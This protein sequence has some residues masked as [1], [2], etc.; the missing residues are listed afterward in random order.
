M[1]LGQGNARRIELLR[2]V[3]AV[4]PEGVEDAVQVRGETRVIADPQAAGGIKGN[5]DPGVRSRLGRLL[6]GCP[7]RTL[8]A[9]GQQVLQ[10]A[11]PGE[12]RVGRL[13]GIAQRA[14][15]VDRHAGGQVGRRAGWRG[16]DGAVGGEGHAAISRH[17]DEVFVT[18]VGRIVPP[19]VPRHRHDPAMI[20]RHGRYHPVVFDVTRRAVVIDADRTGPGPAFVG[21]AHEPDVRFASPHVVP[22]HVDVVAM[23][24][25][26]AR[27]RHHDRED[28]AAEP[29]RSIRPHVGTQL[30]R[31]FRGAEGPATVGRA[32]HEERP[33]VV[34]FRG[35]GEVILVIGHQKGAVGQDHRLGR[36]QL[37]AQPGVDHLP[38]GE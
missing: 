8:L 20:H 26:G 4:D 38:L 9:E 14:Q 33:A 17:G 29:R 3:P 30:E 23:G 12:D 13:V 35:D 21:G 15:I 24:G 25:G 6:S 18:L 36:D 1:S 7:R 19:I 37:P 5:V 22:G 10:R 11:H 34:P 2:P 16:R 32:A 27:I 28:E 31:G